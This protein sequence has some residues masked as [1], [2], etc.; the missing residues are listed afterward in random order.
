[1]LIRG[2]EN[3]PIKEAKKHLSIGKAVTSAV[4]VTEELLAKINSYALEPLTAADVFIGKQLL[5]H[6]GIDRD[7]ERFPEK[8]LDDFEKTLPGKSTLYFH[9]RRD[10]LPLGLYFDAKTEEMSADQFKQLTD[11][12]PKLPEGI[13]S[14]KVL[15]AWYYVILTDDID[16][17]LKNI[18]GGTY[19]HWSISFNAASIVSIKDDPNGPV[20][21]WEY[22]GPAEA[23]EGS[24]V[25]LGAQQGATSQKSAGLKPEDHNSDKEMEIMKNLL[26]KLGVILGKSFADDTTEEQAA[27]AVKAAFDAKDNEISNLQKQVSDMEESA[28][29][30]KK[31]IE[32]TA[33]EYARLKALLGECDE[34]EEAK[35]KM[36]GFAKSMG[37]D[38][39]ELEVKSLTTRVAKKF[40]DGGQL[41]GSEGKKTQTDKNPLVVE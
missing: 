14:V 2:K 40:P 8:V 5:A 31:F 10:Y 3:T 24:L 28:K 35:T 13:S 7:M 25:W 32:N 16:S 23:L 27:T 20:K 1:M 12:D 21:Y 41:S 36:V 9:A 18:K 29:L 38:F 34:S 17:T 19:R 22:V 4:K 11:C 6:N 39:L 26:L 37:I 30:G 15:W 33:T